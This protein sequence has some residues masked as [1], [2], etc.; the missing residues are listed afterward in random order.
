MAQ[1]VAACMDSHSI[2]GVMGC[3]AGDDTIFVAVKTPEGAVNAAKEI[4]R[5]FSV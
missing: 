3:V 5:F 2:S 1:A 4:R